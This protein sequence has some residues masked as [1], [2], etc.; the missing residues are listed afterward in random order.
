[1]SSWRFH[2]KQAL[3]RRH[4]TGDPPVIAESR[5]VVA[6]GSLRDVAPSAVSRLERQ[7]QR[8]PE[9]L[10]RYPTLQAHRCSNPD[11]TLRPFFHADVIDALFDIAGVA[12]EAQARQ[13]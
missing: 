1:M 4:A 12:H 10:H 11:G 7:W 8:H 5:L 13:E 6:L 2:R 3:L 9:M